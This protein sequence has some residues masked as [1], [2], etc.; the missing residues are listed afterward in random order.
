MT[1]MYFDVQ[2]VRDFLLKNAFVAT[3]RDPRVTTERG[4][5][6]PLDLWVHDGSSRWGKPLG[7]NANRVYIYSVGTAEE[8]EG[9]ASISS[10]VSAEEWWAKATGF[11]K[12]SRTVEINGKM[13][14]LW[15]LDLYYVHLLTKRL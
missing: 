12:P 10:F 4:P 13:E 14:S 6:E 9:F 5:V 11:Y 2:Q 1:R 8:C 15:S 7:L 3:L